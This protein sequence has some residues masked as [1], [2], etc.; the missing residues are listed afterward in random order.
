[1]IGRAAGTGPPA[2]GSPGQWPDTSAA[3]A[4]TAWSVA[5]STICTVFVSSG[6]AGREPATKPSGSDQ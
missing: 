1:V 3:C 2:A 5:A 4:V 6:L